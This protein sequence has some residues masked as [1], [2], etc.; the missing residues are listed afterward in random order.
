MSEKEEALRQISEIKN[1]LVDKQT[2]FPYNYNATY[3]WSVISMILT[4]IIVPMYEASVLQGT[5]VVF[6][7]I[8]IGFMTE[9]FLTKKV[10]K[11]Y[12]IEDCTLR[13]QFVMKSFFMV[14]LFLI[15]FSAILASYKLYVAIYLSWLFLI[16][17]VYFAVGFVL[18]IKR[19]TQ[20]ST[21]N[22]FVSI[23]LL[24]IGLLNDVLVGTEHTYFR[25]IQ[26]FMILGLTVMPAIIAWQQ[27][28]EGK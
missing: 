16:S 17:L 13:Q 22:M 15:V 8:A 4:L 7:L 9:G 21:F 12:D 14:A 26:I 27:L 23:L 24:T 6:V 10:N 18:N 5:V 25:V 20:M 11:S 1:H 19:F 28:K 2:F 3:V